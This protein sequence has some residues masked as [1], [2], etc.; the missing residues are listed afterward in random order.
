MAGALT[1]KFR[2]T[3]AFTNTTTSSSMTDSVTSFD[4]SSASGWPTDTAVDVVI[5]RRNADGTANTTGREVKTVTVSGNTLSTS[6]TYGGLDGTT[7]QSHGAAATVELNLTAATHNDMVDGILVA[8]NQDG[9]H[10][11]GAT[12]AS[13][14][15]TGLMDG[16]IGA[17]ETWTYASATTITVPSDATTR[18]SVGDK[19][20]LTQ[21]TV[22]YF[23]VVA[24]SSTVLTVTGGTDYTVANAA[25]SANYYSKAAS[26]VGFPHW[27]AYTPTFTGFTGSV[28]T[29]V[30]T[31]RVIGREC[32]LTFSGT[33]NGTSNATGF[34]ATLPITAATRTNAHWDSMASVTDNGTGQT[35][36]GLV[37]VVSAGTVANLYKDLNASNWTSSS[38]KGA[39][40]RVIYEI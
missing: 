35:A 3:K 14:V 9:T 22:K 27:F 32:H 29:G 15:F 13:P 34:T 4:V 20:K 6:N 33:A 10:L 19:I 39:D 28:P 26:P 23:Y 5:D 24:V 2:K 37:R 12:Y 1:D 16:W 30:T 8:H 25:I 17:N 31:F 40:W 11:S 36:P 18:Y 38:A 21:T 7:R